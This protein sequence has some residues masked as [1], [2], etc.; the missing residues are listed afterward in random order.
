M[1]KDEFLAL[2]KRAPRDLDRRPVLYGLAWDDWDA[3]TIRADVGTH[4]L[5]FIWWTHG[6]HWTVDM[7]GLSMLSG[8]AGACQGSGASPMEALRA[9]YDA[10]VSERGRLTSL[11]RALSKTEIGISRR[12]CPA[13]YRHPRG[14]TTW[15]CIR[16]SGHTG[17]HRAS[18]FSCRTSSVQW[19]SKGRVSPPTLPLNKKGD[20]VG[21][22]T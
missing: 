5:L 20:V 22:K 4:E 19:N 8:R 12:Q 14:S 3:D 11:K 13:V 1:T 9:L 10:V 17:D 15:F 7:R 18:Y 21:D 16:P 6:G 2:L